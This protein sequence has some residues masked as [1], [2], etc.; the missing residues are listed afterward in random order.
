[1][2][3]GLW[4]DSEQE[5]RPGVINDLS[6]VVKYIEG[7]GVKTEGITG[8]DTDLAEFDSYQNA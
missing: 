2:R 5:G 3:N 4:E 6:M 8:H 7:D 1:M